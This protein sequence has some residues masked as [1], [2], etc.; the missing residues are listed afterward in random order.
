MIPKLEI[1]PKAQRDIWNQL[2]NIPQHYVLYGGTAIA[3]RLGHR[4]SVDFDFFSSKPLNRNELLIALP[5]L[6][7]GKIVL[8]E[9]NTLDCFIESQYGSVKL[10]FLGGI[11]KRQGR[12]EDPEKTNDNQIWIA[13]LRDLLATK[14]NTIQARAEI[15]DYID[16]YAILQQGISLEEG[17]G[18]AQAIF[19][20]AFDPGTSIRALCSYHDGDL[21][22]LSKP[23]QTMLIKAALN[24]KTL[25]TLAP[26]SHYISPI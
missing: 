3:L 10:Q 5:F 15:K 1:L 17:L 20:P 12:I 16:I 24:I 19:G 4:Q 14:L 21:S 25:P 6:D 9:I 26:K 8:P 22:Q 11:D 18:C 7:K 23:I 13:S 2:S